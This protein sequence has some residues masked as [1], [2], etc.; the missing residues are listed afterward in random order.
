MTHSIAW[1]TSVLCTATQRACPIPIS[2]RTT[3]P[4]NR[5]IGGAMGKCVGGVLFQHQN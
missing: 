1:S 5:N 4:M 2:P 3:N